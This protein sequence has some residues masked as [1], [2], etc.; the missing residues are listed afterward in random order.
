MKRTRHESFAAFVDAT[1]ASFRRGVDRKAGEARSKRKRRPSGEALEGRLLMA[2]DLEVE[3]ISA[4][5]ALSV[6]THIG[7]SPFSPP[8]LTDQTFVVDTGSGLD[9]TAGR[10][11][12]PFLIDLTIDR[13]IGD[14]DKLLAQG[15]IPSTVSL[16]LP[17]YDV[18]VNGFPGIPPERDRVT[19]IE[20]N[21]AEHVLG[22]LDGDDSIWQI[23]SFAIDTAWL[24]FGSY[25]DQNGYT[26]GQNRLRVD[27]DTASPA[28]QDNW[29]TSID[30]V[31]FKIPAP[32]PVL[33]VHGILS[34]PDTWKAPFL[35]IRDTYGV[36]IGL[37]DLG[38]LDS[39]QNNAAKVDTLYEDMRKLWTTAS[40]GSDRQ[41]QV[42]IVAHSKGG[43]DSRDLI[44]RVD[45]VDKLIQ[46]GTPNAGSPL[47]D[48]VQ[49]AVYRLPAVGIATGIV[50]A[51]AAPAGYQ[52][53]TIY[54]ALYNFDHG[55]N[56]NVE[57]TSIAGD[58]KFGGLLGGVADAAIAALMGGP[59]DTIVPVDSVGAINPSAF[60]VFPSEGQDQQAMH[61]AMTGSAAIAEGYVIP[62]L[63][64][65]SHVSAAL[66]TRAS[67]PTPLAAPSSSSTKSQGPPPEFGAVAQG[68]VQEKSF[69]IDDATGT[70]QFS[71]L[72][73]GS[74]LNL[75]LVSPSGRLIDPAV[76]ALDPNI[77]YQKNEF[78][79]ANKAIVYRL[80]PGSETGRWT[81]RIQGAT[82]TNPGG[83]EFYMALATQETS[84]VSLNIS[85]DAATSIAGEPITVRATVNGLSGGIP[86]ATVEA[87]LKIDA[88][89][90]LLVTLRDD[91]VGADATAGDGTYTGVFSQAVAPG[92]YMLS[93][94]AIGGAAHPFDRETG[95]LAVVASHGAS[96]DDTSVHDQG[97]DAD[98]N[99]LFDSLDIDLNVPAR[100]AGTY[101][102]TATLVDASGHE[103]Q[104]LS[105]S[106]DLA[107]GANL[108]K[109]SFDGRLIYG[110]RSDGPYT[111]R[112][113]TLKEDVNGILVPIG[114]PSGPFTTS[115]LPYTAF[116]HDPI[117][118]TGN[119]DVQ[120]TDADGDGLLDSLEISLEVEVDQAGFY[121]WSGELAGINGQVAARAN[122]T[123]QLV[124]G[125]NQLVL[126]FDGKEI[127]NHDVD[128][129]YSIW[130]LV[131][132]G[133]A[134]SILTNSTF[135]TSAF[136]VTQFENDRPIFNPGVDPTIDEGESVRLAVNAISPRA[137]ATLVYRLGDDA[138]EDATID[139]TTGELT[140]TPKIAGIY[141][142]TILASDSLDPPL[143]AAV[144][145]TITVRNVA[146]SIGA[147]AE[148]IVETGSTLIRDGSFT[149]PG[150]TGTFT[151][152][153]DYGDGSGAQAL[154]LTSER[155]F[156]LAHV[157]QTAGQYTV[158][159]TIVDP[160][161]ARAERQFTVSV[162]PSTTTPTNPTS[163]TPTEPTSPTPTEPTPTTGQE[164]NA[165]ELSPVELGRYEAILSLYKS[166]VGREPV[167]AEFQL[168]SPGLASRVNT[169][170][171]AS[172]LRRTTE[173]RVYRSRMG[174]KAVG[175]GTAV[176]GANRA[177]V[178]AATVATL[179]HTILG[180]NPD[181]AGFA[182]SIRRLGQGTSL[183]T[184]LRPM[185]T[186]AEAHSARAQGIARSNLS[187]VLREVRVN[188]SLVVQLANS[189]S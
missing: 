137:G 175:L 167:V 3:G 91:G 161:N 170:K 35:S 185:Y 67:A 11:E 168:W 30:W 75:T 68:E 124:K 162:T 118:L 93:V 71:L 132:I 81:A 155:R 19:F 120:T 89:T 105:K 37:A 121:Q 31:S 107:T 50:A 114:S 178:N 117:R 66:S 60:I 46:L 154:S 25:S 104:T 23:N 95:V 85:T 101:V 159:V 130:N 171:A 144:V 10:S 5:R 84:A 141:Q 110:A 15:L 165:L 99:G 86:G 12:G 127:G 17:A 116:E 177:G 70:I 113:V 172:V 174:I 157:Y 29:I 64:G 166:L 92:T 102:V 145:R 147:I 33:F 18:D 28:G 123:G 8:S 119:G 90:N 108:I 142:I 122:L 6:A 74:N 148:G 21:G 152:T 40:Y 38:A 58:Y 45:Y 131:L 39:I 146:P 88:S 103:I 32:D 128:G 183:G 63:L 59:S 189:G 76:A 173:A 2:G 149:D 184:L 82:V 83:T 100:I 14:R 13:W 164:F 27:I 22:Y 143:S 151:A 9:V 16:S 48:L 169:S 136:S 135:T 187:K 150:S 80:P 112:A 69:V 163:P 20:S 156:T 115:A 34:G 96:I 54:M 179:Y 106:H 176:R 53:T 188:R 134:G 94:R 26:P 79:P 160:F 98:G 72:Y 186:S 1:G 125:T 24:D 78:D 52:L 87:Y 36:P 65:Y 181:A 140:W 109:L 138:P 51:L 182:S 7:S 49:T 44:D 129:P 139:A 57:Y 126:K 133:P 43:L 158:V 111:V 41:L 4:A 73:G 97:I 42:N 55:L 77:D 62:S 47:A 61:T 153:V 180:R 56:P